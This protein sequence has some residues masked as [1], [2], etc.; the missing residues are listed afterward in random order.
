MRLRDGLNCR[1]KDILLLY[2][3]F[4]IISH[5]GSAHAPESVALNCF[6]QSLKT[7]QL[8]E[9]KQRLNLDAH[10]HGINFN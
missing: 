3:L 4:G 10:F 6:R 1:L 5:Y 8:I 7:R 9:K 2:L